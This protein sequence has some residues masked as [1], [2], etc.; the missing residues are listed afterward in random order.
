MDDDSSDAGDRADAGPEQDGA[1]AGIASVRRAE[2]L[3]PPTLLPSPGF[4]GWLTA[5][6]GTLGFTT[7]QSSRLFLLSG[8]ADGG[9]EALERVVGSA[10][11]LTMRQSAIWVANKEQAWRFSNVGPFTVGER[12]YQALFMP[13]RGHFLGP[14]DTHDLLENVQFGGRRHELLF[15]NTNFDCIAALDPHYGFVPVWQ[16]SWVGELTG[17]DKCH[18]NGIGA[19]DGRLAFATACARSDAPMGWRKAQQ[20]GG[21]AIDVESGAVICAG[22]SMPH[23][24]RWHAGR[25]WLLN[26][27]AGDFGCV[28]L[29]AGR[30]E[31][32]TLCPGFARGLCFVG[33]HAVIGL[34]RLRPNA[35]SSTMPLRS[36]LDAQG[37]RERCGLLVVDLATGRIVHWL[38]IEGGVTELYDVGFLPGLTSVYTPGFSEPGL[39]R[40]IQHRPVS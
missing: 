33:G 8:G 20:D 13:R 35:F 11:G 25:L 4:A 18:L 37:V 36:R 29:A 19:R 40:R 30:F 17:G 28:D 23:S 9:L 34:S 39:H 14:C 26:S 22:L 7:Y 27:G 3:A 2:R 15:A 1:A 12:P 38:T 24:P 10:M 32:V 21:V 5:Q 6:G 31:A 16:P